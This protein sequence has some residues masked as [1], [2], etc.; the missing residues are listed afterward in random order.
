M[1]FS[2]AVGKTLG[3]KSGDALGSDKCQSGLCSRWI[4]AG[5]SFTSIRLYLDWCVSLTQDWFPNFKRTAGPFLFLV[6]GRKSLRERV[7]Q[8]EALS[9][10][11]V[12]TPPPP[13]PGRWGERKDPQP[14]GPSWHLPGKVSA[15]WPWRKACPSHRVRKRGLAS[16][17]WPVQSPGDLCSSSCFP[18]WSPVQ[19]PEVA[20]VEEPPS[21]HV[22]GT[23]WSSEQLCFQVVGARAQGPQRSFKNIWLQLVTPL[24]LKS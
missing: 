13:P 3:R 16:R 11:Q 6:L 18:H 23:S 4:K 5:C 22:W 10:A 24:L 8:K 1:S 9:A 20:L 12:L 21:P 19:L 15:C 14:K 2:G 7:R 17:K